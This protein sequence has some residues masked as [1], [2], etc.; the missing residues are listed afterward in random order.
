MYRAILLS[1]DIVG[2]HR[3][4]TNTS[5]ILH[6]CFTDSYRSIHRLIH[7]S[8]L[9]RSINALVSVDMSADRLVDSS[10]DIRYSYHGIVGGPPTYRS[11]VVICRPISRP[12]GA[13]RYQCTP[14]DHHSLAP[15][16]SRTFD[17][18]PN[19]VYIF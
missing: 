10:V 2:V 1:V 9:D 5:P 7:R 6:R 13:L 19:K 16:Y 17:A 12:T 15:L 4:F 3:Y 18:N 8:I 11:I 14:N